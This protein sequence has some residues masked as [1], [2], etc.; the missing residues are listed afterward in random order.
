MFRPSDGFRNAV[1]QIPNPALRMNET[2]ST[3]D[4]PHG[5]SQAL[6]PDFRKRQSHLP[7]LLR[8]MESG[9]TRRTSKDLALR[10]T[11]HLKATIH[12]RS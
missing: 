11:N 9:D 2:R 4:S 5:C 12:E 3:P 1:F 8:T 10:L 6:N 7:R